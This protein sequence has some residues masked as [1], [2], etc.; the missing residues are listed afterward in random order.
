MEKKDCTN[1]SNSELKIYIETLRN[2][3]ESKKA[4]LAKI[5]EMMGD[6]ENEYLS[7]THELEIRRNILL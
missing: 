3:F 7:A 4:E 1:M 5:C 6:I 2:E